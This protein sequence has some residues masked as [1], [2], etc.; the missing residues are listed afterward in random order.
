MRS[1]LLRIWAVSV[2]VSAGCASARGAAAN[3]ETELNS[4][5]QLLDRGDY[6]TATEQL[7][8]ISNEHP[9]T[10]VGQRAVIALAAASLD[11]RNPNRRID[12][13]ATYAA[14][15]LND[16]TK[17]AWTEP[18]GET[19]YL[20]A[21]ELGATDSARAQA[22]SDA[23]DARAEAERVKAQAGRPLPR[24]PGQS[25]AARM[26]GT[27]VDRDKIAGRLAQLEQQLQ[28]R[29]KQLADSVAELQRIRKT[30]RP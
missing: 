8:K 4:A 3:P 27:E 6:R 1:N 30:L 12:M 28:Q 13:G 29:D 15:Y 14:R 26:K 9:G 25:F 24:L 17:A 5:L 21:L 10:P 16:K 20:M 7:L 11:P 18:V 22:E 23:A 2:L 19:L